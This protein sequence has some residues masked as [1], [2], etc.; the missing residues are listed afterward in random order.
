MLITATC[1]IYLHKYYQI[2][3]F[4]YIETLEYTKLKPN[5]M[6][7]ASTLQFYKTNHL[8]QGT[9]VCSESTCV[10]T[11]E[12]HNYKVKQSVRFTLRTHLKRTPLI[13]CQALGCC[14]CCCCWGSCAVATVW[15]S[16]PEGAAPLLLTCTEHW[17]VM[18]KITIL[19]IV[20][21]MLDKK[22]EQTFYHCALNNSFLFCFTPSLQILHFSFGYIIDN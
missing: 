1:V 17:T 10:D 19:H 8:C 14:C 16:W 22:I 18:N 2:K 11:M 9:K 7:L 13:T 6:R 3:L 20:I 4:K 21:K 15:A 5:H 12:K